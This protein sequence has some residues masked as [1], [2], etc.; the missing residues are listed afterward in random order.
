MS[1]STIP[2]PLKGPIRPREIFFTRRSAPLT[3]YMHPR[4]DWAMVMVFLLGLLFAFLQLMSDPGDVR[5]RLEQRFIAPLIPLWVMGEIAIGVL[6]A[7][8]IHLTVRRWQSTLRLPELHLTSMRPV[9]IAQLMI[10]RGGRRVV[11]A[12]VL[13]VWFGFAVG[14]VRYAPDHLIYLIPHT[15]LALNFIITFQCIAWCQVSISLWQDGFIKPVLT[16]LHLSAVF[17]ALLL[18]FFFTIIMSILFIS[19]IQNFN[20]SDDMA[21][22]LIPVPFALPLWGL[23]FLI[24]RAHA[25]RV[26]QIVMPGIEM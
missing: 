2:V 1:E 19:E 5:P 9:A 7:L 14:I 17:A 16:M 3:R 13:C 4:R 25:A 20:I 6:A 26:E 15:L 18:P 21:H 22:C 11:V 8:T 23:K 12:V 24:A 10:H